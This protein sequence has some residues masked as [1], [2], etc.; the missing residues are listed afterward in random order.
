MMIVEHCGWEEGIGHYKHEYIVPIDGMV[1][2]EDE[3][4]SYKQLSG[5]TY[6]EKDWNNDGEIYIQRVA[7]FEGSYGEEYFTA[8]ELIDLIVHEGYNVQG[9]TRI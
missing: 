8:E 6:I 5:F 3:K 2:I 1:I 7:L 4:H 9:I